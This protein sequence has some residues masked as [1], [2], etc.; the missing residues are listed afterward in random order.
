MNHKQKKVLLI[1]IAVIVLMGLFPPWQET[2]ARENRPLSRSPA[3]YHFI[4]TPP[5]GYRSIGYTLDFA[6]I[7]VQFIEVGAI[8]AGAVLY[9][10]DK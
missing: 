2:R 10:K 6:R 9:L 4:L 8:T 3:G 7:A 5:S 1:G